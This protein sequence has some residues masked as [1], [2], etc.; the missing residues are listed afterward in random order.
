[1]TN[2]AET[3]LKKMSN[4]EVLAV[5]EAIIQG[6]LRYA[7]EEINGVTSDEWMEMVYSEMSNREELK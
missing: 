1:M 6:G 5:W 4:E 3:L 2:F 7:G